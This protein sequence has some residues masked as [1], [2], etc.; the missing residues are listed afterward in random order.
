MNPFGGPPRVS[1][2][3]MNCLSLAELSSLEL[4]TLCTPRSLS[5]PNPSHGS[6]LFA[7]HMP[8]HR[9]HLLPGRQMCQGTGPCF[10]MQR[11]SV[12]G[13]GWHT[14]TI[15]VGGVGERCSERHRGGSVAASPGICGIC[16]SGRTL[17]PRSSSTQGKTI[18]HTG[19]IMRFSLSLF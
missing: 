18:N 1:V 11:N 9:S 4:G 12:P 8:Y 5:P 19:V 7:Y 16:G 17:L 2:R 14:K 10:Q 3:L 15:V 13:I 6:V